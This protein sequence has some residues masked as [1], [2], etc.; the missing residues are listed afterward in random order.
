MVRTITVAKMG[1]S[2]TKVEINGILT[3]RAVVELAGISSF[4]ALMADGRGYVNGDDILADNVTTIIIS[5]PKFEAG[6]LKIV[7][8]EGNEYVEVTPGEFI[9]KEESDI[10]INIQIEI[11]I[12]EDD[13]DEVFDDDLFE[14]EEE[15]EDLPVR[16]VTVAKMGTAGTPVE[17]TGI[18]T[19]RHVV[20]LAG[21]STFKAL[22]ADGCGYVNADD[23]LAANVTTIIIS[24]PKFE[25]GALPAGLRLVDDDGVE[26]APVAAAEP[27]SSA[28]FVTVAKMGTAGVKVEIIGVMTYRAVAEEAG[29]EAFK[30]LMAD[31]VGY[32][33]PDD[34]LAASVS[35]IVLSAPKFEA[36][37]LPAGLRIVDDN[38]VE[39][40][41]VAEATEIEPEP[42][43]R[44]V[45]V[46]KMGTAGIKVE[47]V[48]VMTYRAVVEE[49]GIE[50]FKALMAD[51]VGYVNPD[52]ILAASVSTIVLSAP[53]FE[54]GL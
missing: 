45:T 54:A 46:A 37:A 29:F 47:I 42:S 41:P 1:T 35:T 32:V 21:I 51:G 22:M 49:A 28:R 44:F 9:P 33:N 12:T 3:Y 25:A 4:K 19:Y 40:A 31:G 50:S 17:V 36:G 14:D 5:A 2:G 39:Y 52:D 7:D 16:I 34:I 8:D 24:A 38:G 48:G 23:I 6:A 20:E 26:Y 15:E 27:E 30:A 11:N 18:V 10:D 43:A 13:D 53:K